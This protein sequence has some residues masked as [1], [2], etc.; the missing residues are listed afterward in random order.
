MDNDNG[1]YLLQSVDKALAI[2]DL[3]TV[4]EELTA[5]D[6]ARLTGNGKS[7]TFRLLATIENRKY[8]RRDADGKYRLGLKLF[9]MRSLMDSRGDIA[10]S[11]RPYLVELGE[12]TGETCHLSVIS[13]DT[14]VL[15]IDKVMGKSQIRSD[16]AVGYT[17]PMYATS[18]GKA[19]LAYRSRQFV[20]RYAEHLTFEQ[21][22]PRSLK[23]V[24]ELYDEL[25]KVRELGYSVDDEE[26]EIGLT[27]FGAALLNASGEPIAA[28]CVSGPS[29]RMQM[30]RDNHVKA[31]LSITKAASE[32]FDT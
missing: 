31:L 25:D 24:A 32:S 26:F 3:F 29:S 7:T 1:Q 17:R 28:L 9:S 30:N 19:M 12:R 10:D 22:T 20:R 27:C 23:N 14:D 4:Y 5:A 8:L 11:M 16:S 6:I 13:G 21:Y 18:A 2:I 15:F